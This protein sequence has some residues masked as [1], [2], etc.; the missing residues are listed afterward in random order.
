M[1]KV[2]ASGML[3]LSLCFSLFGT[4]DTVTLEHLFTQGQELSSD[5]IM[6]N[7]T[8][9]SKLIEVQQQELSGELNWTVTTGD[10][11]YYWNNGDEPTPLNVGGDVKASRLTGSPG[12]ILNIPN[13]GTGVTVTSPFAINF[14]DSS[15]S[16]VTPG[17]Q[18][19]QEIIG[20]GN[21]ENQLTALQV[22]Q[23]LLSAESS[24]HL[25]LVQLEQSILSAISDYFDAT[26]D[27]E[28]ALYNQNN[29]E[30]QLR[31]VVEVLGYT[32]ETTTYQEA[33]MAK[34][35]AE[36][37]SDLAFFELTQTE[38]RL[39]L[40]TGFRTVDI[41]LEDMPVPDPVLDDLRATTSLMS[42]DIAVSL[43]ELS[44]GIAT[45]KTVFSLD[46]T[47][48]AHM[49][50]GNG[51]VRDTT[52]STGLDATVGEGLSFG[53][54]AATNIDKKD[55]T[56]GISFTYTPQVSQLGT[57]SLESTQN[58][59]YQSLEQRNLV[60]NLYG[61]QQAQL[62]NQITLWRAS[63]DLALRRHRVAENQ[64]NQ[65]YRL[66]E[67]GYSTDLSLE[68]KALALVEAENSVMQALIQGLLLERS[69]QSFYHS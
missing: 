39:E 50:V 5:Y 41:S 58:R 25:A 24:M 38:D 14:N 35:Q 18:V 2:L 63:Y 45:A 46:G 52:F 30:V 54:S 32:E 55:F 37:A 31:Q 48:G 44:L 28:T 65:E 43:A 12:F 20:T 47:V 10:L 8:Y 3:L 29:A 23:T 17:V 66:Y 36:Q 13:S 60:Q 56:G 11:T 53:L 69:I 51:D 59:Y 22:Q 68:G 21:Y 40:L 62:E 61:S 67:D 4:E 49:T 15:G 6:A 16:S 64:Y 57:L 19:S 42:T 7:Y 1:K 27:Y 33:V 34:L 26:V 9:A